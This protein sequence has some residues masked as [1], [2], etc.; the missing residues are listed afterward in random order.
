MQWMDWR[1]ARRTAGQSQGRTLGWTPVG[2]AASVRCAVGLADGR[3][4]KTAVRRAVG[5]ANGRVDGLQTARRTGE[6]TS[7]G[8]NGHLH[9]QDPKPPPS[10]GRSGFYPGVKLTK[11]GCQRTSPPSGGRP[12]FG[13]SDVP[14]VGRPDNPGIYRHSSKGFH[15]LHYQRLLQSD[16]V[17]YQSKD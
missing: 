2:T 1:T 6:H 4:G 8:R 17:V 3:P 14:D 10:A 16:S 11:S 7:T 13:T 12:T 15:Q 5:Y 9:H